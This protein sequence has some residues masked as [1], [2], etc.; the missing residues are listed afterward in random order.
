MIAETLLKKRT[1]RSY[2]FVWVEHNSDVGSDGASGDVGVELDS[3]HTGRSVGVHNLT[4]GDSI[5]GVVGDVLD[6]VNVGNS[7]SHVPFGG[8]LILAVL[9]DDQSLVFPLMGSSS[10][11]TSEDSLLV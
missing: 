6:L 9:D 4:P 7:L 1:S 11:E 10:S 8:G 2:G 3:N 5:S